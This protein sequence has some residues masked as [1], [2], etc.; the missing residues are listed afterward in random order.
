MIEP[1]IPEPR[2]TKGRKRSL[3]VDTLGRVL[4]VAVLPADLAERH[5]LKVLLEGLHGSPTCSQWLHVADGFRDLEVAAAGKNLNVGLDVAVVKH[6][7]ANLEP[8]ILP[9][10]WAGA[11]AFG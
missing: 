6:S 8:K 11:R 5:G 3:L 4:G 10:R 1:L 9:K 2:R 7:D